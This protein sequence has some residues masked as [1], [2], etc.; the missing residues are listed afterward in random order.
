MRRE[1]QDTEK[2]MGRPFKISTKVCLWK[3]LLWESK[4][5]ASYTASVPFP[6]I[7]NFSMVDIVWDNLSQ[8]SVWDCWDGLVYLV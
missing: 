2:G 7:I 6:S 8:E 1:N 5:E 3:D 4:Y